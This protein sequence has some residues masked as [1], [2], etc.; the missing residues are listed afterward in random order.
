[1]ASTPAGGGVPDRPL[2]LAVVG[3]LNLDHLLEVRALPGR[4]RTVPATARRVALGGTAA[5]VALS[6][7]HWGVR[8]AVISRVGDDYPPEFLT[9]LE[10]AGLDLRGVTPV[11]GIRSSACVI[12][13]DQK[14]GQ[15]TIIDQGPMAATGNAPIPEAVL[16]DAA[17]VHLGTGDPPYLARVAERARAR[18]CKVA[19]DPAQEIHYRWTARS[20]RPYAAQAE[21]LFGNSHEIAAAARLLGVATPRELTTRVPLVVMTRGARGA[22]AYFRGG[23]VEVPAVPAGPVGDPTGA[24]DAFRGGFYAGWFAGEPLRSCLRAGARAAAEWLR[25]RRP[26]RPRGA[27]RG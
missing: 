21:L 6:A 12:V 17:W 18:G 13:H 22:R 27:S 16:A 15:L 10:R 2:D 3:H 20:L 11:P 1:M 7:A 5:N 14:G 24:G 23:S 26:A 4:D 9:T 25:G 19:I 8:T